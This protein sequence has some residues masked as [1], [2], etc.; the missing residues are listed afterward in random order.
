MVIRSDS[1]SLTSI[2]FLFH[3]FLFLMTAEVTPYPG[4]ESIKDNRKC[5][6]SM[7]GLFIKKKS[8]KAMR[9]S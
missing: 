1:G 5:E 8:L 7:K 6:E 2:C 9:E 3:F 4:E